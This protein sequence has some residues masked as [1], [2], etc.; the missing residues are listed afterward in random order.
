MIVMESAARPF[1]VELADL[2]S[3]F[4]GSVA[5]RLV[6]RAA[7]SEVLITGCRSVESDVITVGA[8]LPRAHSFYESIEGRW[9]D[10][11]LV[12]EAIRQAGLVIAHQEFGVPFGHQFLM[13]DMTYDVDPGGLLVGG[14]PADLVLSVE[15]G[16]IVRRGYYIAG[17]RLDVTIHRDGHWIGT[18]S[19][20]FDCVSPA[21]YSRMRALGGCEPA[22]PRP[23]APVPPVLVGRER[24]SDVVLS[25]SGRADCWLLR[26]DP[27]HPVLFDHPVDHAPGMLL[28]EAARQA[29][30]ALLGSR[31]MGSAAAP[32]PLAFH[33]GYSRYVELNAPC[34]VRAVLLEQFGELA[35][36]RVTIEQGGRSAVEARL[37]MRAAVHG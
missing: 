4:A 5:R 37:T 2:E 31:G 24:A 12:A 32:L 34:L 14:L 25:P 28:A 16:E 21:V 3:L 6:H 23:P 1:R 36:V 17:A 15:T 27:S 11:M 18:G 26:A 9:H 33:I 29:A 35:L 19:A 10:P 8:Q 30:T 22:V 7:I 13:Q 20:R